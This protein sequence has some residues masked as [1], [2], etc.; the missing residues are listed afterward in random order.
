MINIF[1]KIFKIKD[2]KLQESIIQFIKFG[3]VGFSNV[4]VSYIINICTLLLLKKYNLPYDFIIGNILSFL[5]SVLW[6]FYWNNKYVFKNNSND[7]KSILKKL[8]KTYI[9]YSFSCIILNNVLSL[10]W[11]EILRISKYIAPIINLIVTI[12]IN[13]IINKLWAFKK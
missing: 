1:F 10:V 12:P 3:I 7:K 4:V 2:E 8:L 6:S 9:A 13:F 5:L 11:I